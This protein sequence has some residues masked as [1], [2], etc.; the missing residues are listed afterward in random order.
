MITRLR[1]FLFS[2]LRRQ[3]IFSVVAVYA[4]LT[5]HLLLDAV[6]R[7]K[8]LTVNR[9]VEHATVLSPSLATSSAAWVLTRNV[10]GLQELWGWPWST[11]P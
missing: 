5:A 3:L 7:Q 6:Q 9:Q 10:S 4:G 8:T 2:T 11:A 1:S